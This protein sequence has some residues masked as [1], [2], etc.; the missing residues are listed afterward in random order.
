MVIRPKPNAKPQQ[1]QRLGRI[2][3]KTV[4]RLKLREM[5]RPPIKDSDRTNQNGAMELK[6]DVTT[7][8]GAVPEISR[9]G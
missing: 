9:G 3:S 6:G 5:A 8:T 1:P 2:Q 4:V 7:V